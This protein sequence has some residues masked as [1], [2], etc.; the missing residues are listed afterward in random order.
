MLLRLASRLSWGAGRVA[1]ANG[2]SSVAIFAASIMV[3]RLGGAIELGRYGLIIAL[4]SVVGGVVDLGTDRVL[5]QRVAETSSGWTAAWRAMIWLKGGG[6]GIAFLVGL[7]YFVVRGDSF[8]VLLVLY[9][10][11]ISTWLTVQGLAS[12]LRRLGLYTVF[13]I[14]SRAGGFVTFAATA[15]L[16]FRAHPAAFAVIS[17]SVWDVASAC[18]MWLAGLRSDVTRLPS[19]PASR[20]ASWLAFRQALPLGVSTLATWLYVKLDTILLGLTSDL[21]TLGAYTAAVRLAELLGGLSTALNA[22]LLPAFARLSATES[23]N[24]H[25]ARD[26]AIAGVTFSIGLLCLGVFCFADVLVVIAFKLPASA[27]YLQILVWGQIYAAAGVICAVV[28]QVRGRGRSIAEITVLTSIISIPLYVVLIKIGGA[29]GAAV[30]T[31]VSYALILPIGLRLRAART[32][33]VPLLRASIVLL[34]AIGA[35]LGGFLYVGGFTGDRIPHAVAAMVAYCVVAAI[36]GMLLV[37]VTKY[38]NLTPPGSVR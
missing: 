27:L 12:A 31:V 24:L 10:I 35:G 15:T 38:P 6:L 5:T 21:A 16:G 14:V 32:T 17:F 29:V 18:L 9:G 33:F 22:V 19:A 34:P 2:V 1:V 11:A 25:R 37:R 36:G 3:V 20:S 28:L 13:R 26:A 4:G 30:A 7:L 8:E 23:E